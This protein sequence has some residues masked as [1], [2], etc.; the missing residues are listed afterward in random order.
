MKRFNLFLIGIMLIGLCPQSM[1]AY[2]MRIMSYNIRCLSKKDGPKNLWKNRRDP[3]GKYVAS[4]HPDIFGMQEVTKSQLDDILERLPNYAYIGVGRDD[5][6]EKGEYSPIF[7]RTDKFT[8]V[9]KGGFWLSETPDVPSRGWDA[10]CLRNTSWAILEDVKTKERF[11]YCNTHFDHI[12]VTARTNSAM[13]SKDKFKDLA[14]NLPIL[15]TA[16]FNTNEKEQTYNLL[17]SYEY[18]LHDAWKTAK[19]K[20]GGPATYNDWGKAKNTEDHKIDFIFVSPS[21]KVKKAVISD[22]ALG[23]GY[24]RSDH[25]ALW[26][27]VKW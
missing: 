23:D 7:Y 3:L 16:D 6:K 2:K 26:A 20:S 9:E 8:V 4:V 5:G 1:K 17:C 11:F 27:D 12:S 22:S 10:S 14:G 18:P 25:N 19:K 13:L 15:F 24:Y 21:I